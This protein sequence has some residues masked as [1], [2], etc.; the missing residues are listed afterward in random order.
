VDRLNGA[1]LVDRNLLIVF[2]VTLLAVMGVSSI[3]PVL[4][5]VISE[6]GITEAEAGLLITVFTLPGVFL[7][8]F[9]GVLADRI[10]R[11]TILVPSLV[12]FGLAGGL[13]GLARS[14]HL[15]LA[16]RFL[17]GTGAAAL[18]S[19]N[20]TLIGD[21]YHGRQRP[22]AMG[23]NASVLSVG[24][25]FYPLIGGGLAVLAWSY[26]FFLPWLALPLALAVVNSLRNPEP[27]G[28]QAIGEYLRGIWRGLRNPRIIGVFLSGVLVFIVLYGSYL[29]YFSV[30]LGHGFGASPLVIG[31]VMFSMSI[32]TAAV[33]SQ[34][35]RLSR[36]FGP[37]RL[38]VA[39]FAGY[40]VSLALVPFVTGPWWLLGP[41]LLF[42]VAHGLGLPSLQTMLAGETPLDY[43][44]MFMSLNGTM[45]RIG[46]TLGPF[47][48]GVAFSL[49]N[50]RGVFW[51]GT[52][53]AALGLAVAV[54][55]LAPAGR[56]GEDS[57]PDAIAGSAGP[58]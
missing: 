20:A 54:T 39:S 32:T 47:L 6:F 44:A 21:L 35:G 43:R 37:R 34:L 12:L 31:L 29:T 24:T 38:V 13:C 42:G 7:T 41:T 17:Q 22:R 2:G 25:A 19:L 33:S 52:L 4:P 58:A 27:S 36:R 46:Q 45:L 30:L 3:A 14:F 23:L 28:S 18:G 40:G 50:Y 53:T 8:P 48:M 5:Q 9:L 16:L 56:P 10:G 11:K 57:E 1:P 15:L 55:M 26:P 49:W 51:G